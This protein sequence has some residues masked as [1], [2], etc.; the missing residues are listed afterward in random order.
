MSFKE[1]CDSNNALTMAV[2]ELQA[3]GSNINH[4]Y[5]QDKLLDLWDMGKIS[6]EELDEAKQLLE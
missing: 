5:V 4:A 2:K 6:K 3:T 1:I